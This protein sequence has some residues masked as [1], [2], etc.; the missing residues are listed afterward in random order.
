MAATR[1]KG[2]DWVARQWGKAVKYPKTGSG[3]CPTSRRHLGR[4]R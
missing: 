2:Q 3:V 4:L 1:G